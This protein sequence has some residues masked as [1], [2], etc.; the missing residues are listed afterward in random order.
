M[1]SLDFVFFGIIMVSV[2]MLQAAY[3]IGKKE[4]VVSFDVLKEI[5]RKNSEIG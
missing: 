2:K 5:N 1:E 4:L 3:Y